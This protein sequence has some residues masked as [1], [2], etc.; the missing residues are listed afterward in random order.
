[1]G[2]EFIQSNL[3]GG[4]LAPTLHARIDIDKYK[5]SVAHAENVIIVPQGGLR[6]RP[7]LSKMNDGTVGENAR[8]I[9]FVFNKTQQYLLIFRAGY[10]DILRDGVT[11]LSDL[12]IP[13]GSME[14][15]DEL[16]IIQ[17][18]DTVII[19]HKFYRPRMIVRKDSDSIWEVSIVPLVVPLEN[20]T[21]LPYRYENNGE[22]Q[23]IKP[24]TDDIVWN[25]DENDTDGAHNRFYRYIGTNTDATVLPETLASQWKDIYSEGY[26][27]PDNPF[28]VAFRPDLGETAT[29][30]DIAIEDFTIDTVWED[31]EV[32]KEPVWSNIRGYPVSCTFHKGRLWFGGSL[33]KP[34]TVW[35]SRINGFFDFTAKS[36]SGT[37]PDDHAVSDTIEAGQYNKIIN[38]F[39]GRGL[40]IFTTGSEYY[41]KTDVITPS[42]SNWEVQTGY[43][44]KGIRPIFIDG[45]TLFIDSSGKTIRE[46]VYNFDEDA[47]VSNSITLLASH[48]LTDI[49]SIAAIK[50]T[51][52]DV[53]DFVYV[54]NADGTLA[55]MNTLRN[56]S[57]LGWTHWTTDGEFIDVCVVDKDVYFLVKREGEYF[58]ELLNE[59][60]YTDHSV[61]QP[62]TEP[63]QHNVVHIEDNVI[64]GGHNVV[65]TD[66]S[67]G[68]PITELDTD[69][70]AVFDN[71]Y[72]KVVAD[73]SIQEDAKPEVTSPG[74]NKF[75]ITRDA[76]RLE[77][78]LNYDVKITTLPLSTE[79]RSGATLHRRKRIVKA[80]I[81][82]YE[83]LGV[84][85][86][87]IHASDRKF[88]VALDQAPEPFTGFKELYLLGYGRIVQLEITQENPL[89]M[90]VRAI[91]HEV[92][93]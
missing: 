40:Q 62:G 37:I 60:S 92:A 23:K 5:T 19:T 24:K 35:G 4:E 7:G 13:Y 16:D 34:T 91:G 69:F 70:D 11:V 12:V 48:L 64:Y 65:Y 88:T 77:V 49:T 83:S 45:A 86:K 2:S 1:M 59:D 39:S 81:N 43:G 30:I 51:D 15:I 3:T 79:L 82:V 46:F 74:D 18:A 50:G 73:F 67:T 25:N 36:L 80:D 63:D 76:Y 55:V 72:F 8:L 32:G 61:V 31:L 53:S 44:S 29:E 14:L 90:L 89:P 26:V 71:K 20:Y 21:G 47:H 58:I 6:R 22:E 52:I 56:E 66:F 38:I 28:V 17:S 57:I 75:T 27:S 9:P 87:N 54:V 42:D 10:V 41:N 85:V 78:G 68:S 33:A 84:Y 93:Y